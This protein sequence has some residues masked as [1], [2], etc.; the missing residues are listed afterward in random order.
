M[1]RCGAMVMIVLSIIGKFGALFATVPDPVIGGIFII[2]FGLITAVG[3]SA[4]QY[5]DLSSMR[6]LF[7]LGT[8]LFMGLVV[9]LS[10]QQ[11]KINV[12]GKYLNCMLLTFC[13]LRFVDTTYILQ[14]QQKVDFD[15]MLITGHWVNFSHHVA[16]IFNYL[17]VGTQKLKE[18]FGRRINGGLLVH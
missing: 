11:K 16:G 18:T 13:K 3:L 5:V 9:P 4:L 12:Y 14:Q 1:I 8:S 2:M 6:N 15:E 10:V 17:V 7:V